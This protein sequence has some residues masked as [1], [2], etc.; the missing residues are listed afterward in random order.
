MFKRLLSSLL[1]LC[2]VLLPKLAYSG[3]DENR[4]TPSAQ[5]PAGR[6]ARVRESP[7]KGKAPHS[8]ASAYK[9][10]EMLGWKLLVHEDLIAD[11][12]LHKLTIDEVHHQLFRITRVVP[13]E[14]VKL[15]RQVPI[16]IELKNPYSSNCQ[17]HPSRAWLEGN[18]YLPEK[19]NAVELSNAKSFLRSSQGIQPFVLL[20]E[21]AHA[22]HDLH[23]GFNDAAI[24]ECY[25]KAKAS[26]AYDKVLHMVGRKVSAYAMVDHKEY[27]AE[28]TEAFFGTNDHY[29]FVRAELK[30]HDPAIFEVL[31]E[32]WGM[33]K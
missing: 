1:I 24:L 32:V 22:Y 19:A 18:G 12:E 33:N 3:Q 13:E 29:P 9:E 25:K 23:L 15:L 17:Y 10:A 11:E 26:G 8:A 16:W 4:E 31:R 20:H 21:L 27:F 28:A 7:G 14:K 30:E 5:A 6:D 2:L